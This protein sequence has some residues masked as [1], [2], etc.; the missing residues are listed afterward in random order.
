[1]NGGAYDVIVVGGGPA[2]STMAWSLAR[3]GA[4]VAVI[5]RAAFPREK[6]CGDFVEPG[7]LRILEAMGALEGLDGA[8][9]SP[10]APIDSIQAFI[11]FRRAYGGKIPYYDGQHGLPPHGRVVPRHVLD[12]R[13][14]D[15]A[16]AASATV[17]EGCSATDVR[18]EAGLTH[19]DVRGENTGFTLSARIV[20]GADG[21]ES[22]VARKAGLRRADRRY[23]AI[24]QRAYVA[25]V[26]VD[27]GQA[28]VW[29]DED[30]AP[31]YGWLFPMPGGRANV[32]VGVLG[33]AC[34]RHQLSVPRAFAAFL[35][36]MRIRVPGC[37]RM[38]LA[39][40]TLGGVVRTYGGAGPNHFDGGLLIGD[41]GAFADPMTAEGITQGM[42]SALIACLTVMEALEDGRFD[43]AY[44]SRFEADFRGYFDPS[45]LYLDLCAALMRNWHLRAFWLRA[46]LHGFERA[47]ADPGFARVAGSTFGG[48]DPR[49]LPI[50]GQ[51]TSS[52]MSWLGRGAVQAFAGLVNG[53]GPGA[54]ALAGDLA[55]WEQGWRAS[56]AHDPAW[57]FAW[58]ADVARKAVRLQT[59][60]WT[61]DNPRVQGPPFPP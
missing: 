56:L 3:R 48:P 51:V 6:V 2:G 24:S 19:V 4:R 44:L 22:T 7:G 14:L 9:S 55:T 43:A 53:S 8:A 30:L 25:D 61:S 35:E 52:L 26:A 13:L 11:G 57:H 5:E 50:I 59:T 46:S 10:S 54:G 31:G 58:L 40:K 17:L 41:A 49:P 42:E 21:A 32:G 36:K 18:R 45:M 1:V 15:C 39:S 20:V 23:M 34:H 38:T 60:L 47:T 37:A 29:F 12:T 16:R 33:E 28:T 27:P